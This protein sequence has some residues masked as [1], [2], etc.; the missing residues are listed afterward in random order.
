MRTIALAITAAFA[1]AQ[2]F[3]DEAETS[4]VLR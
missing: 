4:S 1:V 2:R 3:V